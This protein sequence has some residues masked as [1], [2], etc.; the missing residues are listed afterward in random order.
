MTKV[1]FFSF[2]LLL[3]MS[4]ATVVFHS[5]EAVPQEEEMDPEQP[6]DPVLPSPGTEVTINGVTWATRNV[7]APGTF[8]ADFHSF[9]MYYQWNKKTA[10]STENPLTNTDGG[11]TWNTTPSTENSWAKANDPCPA[12]WRVPTRNEINT[13]LDTVKVRKD[14]TKVNNVKGWMQTDKISGK[15]LF[16]PAAGKRLYNNGM[17]DLVGTN[18]FYW[19]SVRRNSEDIYYLY[20]S[21]FGIIEYSC[22]G[23][24]AHSIRCVKE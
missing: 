21:S 19:S 15:S 6:K 12:G 3:T 7:A 8:A 20:F 1:R 11:T 5:C 14:W 24:F 23:I 18:G 16:L 9:G 22:T 10:W 13:L 2:W 17:L 4:M